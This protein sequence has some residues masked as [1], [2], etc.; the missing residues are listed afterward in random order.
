MPIADALYEGLRAIALVTG[1]LVA[2]DSIGVLFGAQERPPHSP[3][4]NATAW[5]I[6][7]AVVA[8]VSGYLT[9]EQYGVIG[10]TGTLTYT[11]ILLYGGLVIAFTIRA[12][13]RAERPWL[14]VI[15]ACCMSV[16]AVGIGMVG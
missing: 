9:V 5:L 4:W 15:S 8:C 6:A 10:T 1:I 3:K 7:S 2:I 16:V 14:T 13:S 12:V 11:P